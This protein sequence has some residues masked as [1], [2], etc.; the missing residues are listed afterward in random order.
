[1]VVSLKKQPAAG[2][3]RA[4]RLKRIDRLIDECLPEETKQLAAAER[5]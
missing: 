3:Q 4:K 1:M 2:K 5:I